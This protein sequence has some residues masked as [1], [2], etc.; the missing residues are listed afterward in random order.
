M[1]CERPNLTTFRMVR[2][3]NMARCIY[4]T[5]LQ[6]WRIDHCSLCFGL[7]CTLFRLEMLSGTLPTI[8]NLSPTPT[9]W[10][11]RVRT[12]DNMK[13]RESVS[14]GNRFNGSSFKQESDVKNGVSE[15]LSSAYKLKLW[16][17]GKVTSWQTSREA[18]LVCAGINTR[19]SS[20][21]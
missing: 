2:K 16:L 5:N 15:L 9:W 18:L 12:A 1:N 19:T 21:V 11:P 8:A 13:K 10:G 17:I 7:Y 6:M 4:G 3:L 20:Q 14:H